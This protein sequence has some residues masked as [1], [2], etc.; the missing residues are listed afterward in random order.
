[1]NIEANFP[2]LSTAVVMGILNITPDSFYDGGRYIERTNYLEQTERMLLDGASI[3]DIGGAS[4]RPG[5]SEVG[6]V[7]EWER[8]LPVLKD[9]R[10]AFPECCISVDTFHSDVAMKA[11]EHGADMINDISG[12]TFDPHM[13]FV[14]GKHNIPYVIM[15][16]QGRPGNMQIDPQYDNVINDIRDFFQ[17]QVNIFTSHGAQRLVLDPGFGFGKTLDHNYMILREL[18]HLKALGYPLMVGLSR[19]SMIN[20]VLK[21]KPEDALNATSSLNTI[22]LLNGAKILRVHDVKEA[23]EVVKLVGRLG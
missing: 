15:H 3:I 1:M 10:K 13:P 7:T 12:G 14:I 22:A 11:I 9:I 20:K 4:S 5:A 21:T 6:A 16:M 2:D 8:I 17:K 19:K 23:V 18:E